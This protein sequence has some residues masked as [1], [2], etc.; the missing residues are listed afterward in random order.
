MNN[1]PGMQQ[2]GNKS[3]ENRTMCIRCLSPINIAGG[4]IN[5]CSTCSQAGYEPPVVSKRRDQNECYDMTACNN[6]DRI[7]D[8]K[9][10][11]G[12]TRKVAAAPSSSSNSTSTGHLSKSTTDDALSHS[13]DTSRKMWNQV[14]AVQRDDDIA[15]H[16]N[17]AVEADDEVVHSLDLT[18]ESSVHSDQQQL[19]DRTKDKLDN[20]AKKMHG[21]YTDQQS[22]V[23][24]LSVISLMQCAFVFALKLFC[25]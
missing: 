12:S 11:S 15:V 18:D 17:F 25:A 24:S 8:I 16:C 21:K 22:F 14:D 9:T 1:E 6:S 4:K 23:T 13:C 20:V 3:D 7:T 19:K 10:P 5:Q 2:N